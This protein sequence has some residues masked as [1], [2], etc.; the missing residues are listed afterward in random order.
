MPDHG[1]NVAGLKTTVL[2]VSKAGSVFRHMT[3]IGKFHGLM[4]PT[5][6]IGSIFT[7]VV[8]SRVRF[9]DAESK[10]PGHVLGWKPPFKSAQSPLGARLADRFSIFERDDARDLFARGLEQIQELRDVPLALGDGRLSPR[11]KRVGRGIDRSTNVIGRRC[12][13]GAEIASA[14]CGVLVA[15]R[16]AAPRRSPSS[17]YEISE[18]SF[19]HASGTGDQGMIN[20]LALRPAARLSPSPATAGSAGSARPSRRT[21]RWQLLQPSDGSR[22][23]RRRQAEA[24]DG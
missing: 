12:L 19:D 21:P 7:H 17:V 5:T 15:K 2:P 10:K 11:A 14:V 1:V 18:R 24:R 3:F 9:C 23:R 6:P 8:R 13:K 20:A 22:A 4:M 16:G